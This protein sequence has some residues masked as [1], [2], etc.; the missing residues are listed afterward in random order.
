VWMFDNKEFCSIE[1]NIVAMMC[2]SGSNGR[3]MKK[4]MRVR[5]KNK[6]T[7]EISYNK[8]RAKLYHTIKKR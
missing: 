8:E 3:K 5:S 2:T 7:E 6:E 4:V 1:T